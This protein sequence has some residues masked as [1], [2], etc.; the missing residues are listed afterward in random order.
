M[1][2]LLLILI[3]LLG[4][5]I[6]FAIKNDGVKTWAIASSLIT[7]VLGFVALYLFKQ[8][9]EAEMLRLNLPWIEM[10]NA[11]FVIQ[12]DGMNLMLCLLTAIA[13]PLIFLAGYEHNF[14]R[15]HSFYGLMLLAQ[16]GLMGVFLA[17]DA[18]QFY[19]FWELALIPVYFLCSMWGGEKRVPVTFKF[20]VYTFAGSLLMLV[21]IISM[22]AITDSFEW[23]IW[24]AAATNGTLSAGAQYILFCL[25]FVAFAIKMPVFPFHTWQP[26][27]YEQSATPVTMV[28]SGIMVKMGIFAVIRW[29]LPVM[30]AGVAH[31]SHV[32][33][34]LSVIGIVYAS[35]LAWM[36]SDIK[37]IV[38]Y[39]SIAHIGLM[40]AAIFA[41]NDISLQG[42]MAQMFS[43]GVNIIGMWAIVD[44]IERRTGTRNI[45]EMGGIATSAP[46]LAIC[47]VIVAFANIALPLTNGFIGEFLMFNGLFLYNGWYMVF[48]GLGVILGAVYTLNMVQ[49]VLYGPAGSKTNGIAD[50]R[51]TEMVAMVVVVAMILVIGVYPKP[52]LNLTEG[53]VNMLNTLNVIIK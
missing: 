38:A 26:D 34:V 48:A 30:P 40:C 23:S 43:H 35:L 27:T 41:R 44:A 24:V 19:I 47:L 28:L 22:Y 36:Q 9:P 31:W 42:V 32:V 6:S 46:N 17:W 20:F 1:L 3:P 5:L 16:A 52:L 25:F 11:R 13:F 45:Y 37:R 39:S 53:T 7:A 10:L 4:G 50:L 14:D 29:V 12:L 33:V 21:G 18:L 51:G 8:N 49:K 2:T 15:K